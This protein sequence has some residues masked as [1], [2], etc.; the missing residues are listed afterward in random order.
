MQQRWMHGERKQNAKKGLSDTFVCF[1]H[2]LQIIIVLFQ[3]STFSLR[4]QKIEHSVKEHVD[5]LE[6]KRTLRKLALERHNLKK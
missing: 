1:L 6:R 2:Q 4:L 3:F 5:T